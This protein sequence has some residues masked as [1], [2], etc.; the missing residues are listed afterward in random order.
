MLHNKRSHYNE[1]CA[2]RQRITTARY[3]RESLHA[4]M[5]EDPVLPKEKKILIIKKKKKE[6]TRSNPSMRRGEYTQCVWQDS[7][8]T[9]DPL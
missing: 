7:G 2:L 3:T 8:V 1:T 4:A 6:A 9:G 5:N